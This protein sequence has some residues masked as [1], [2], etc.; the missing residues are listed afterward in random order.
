MLDLV[1]KMSNVPQTLFLK[2]VFLERD[3]ATFEH[4]EKLYGDDPLIE[5][6]N[7][8]SPNTKNCNSYTEAE[9]VYDKPPKTFTKL[10]LWPTKTNIRC[11]QCTLE[12]SGTPIPI[13]VSVEFYKNSAGIFDIKWL[14]CTFVCSATWITYNIKQ[15]NRRWRAL[16]MLNMIRDIFRDEGYLSSSKHLDVSFTTKFHSVCESQVVQQEFE[17]NS[18]STIDFSACDIKSQN[19]EITNSNKISTDIPIIEENYELCKF[20]GLIPEK[21]YKIRI[22]QLESALF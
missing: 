12:I 21:E 8:N 7:Y 22:Q 11:K 6:Y 13:P 5:S 17:S 19:Y 20:G 2:G 1:F 15:S 10:N 4:F 18:F 9:I 3:L 14:A 16:G